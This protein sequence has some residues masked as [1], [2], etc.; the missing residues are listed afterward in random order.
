M[1]RRPKVIGDAPVEAVEATPVVRRRRRTSRVIDHAA[2]TALLIESLLKT[3]GSRGASQE[4]LQSVVNWA[5][6]VHA[7]T[8]E[9]KTLV[10]RPRRQK[11]LASPDRMAA[12]ELNKALLESALAGSIGLDVNENGLIVF[13][14][15]SAE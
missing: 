11:A 2:Q 8:E 1:G 3:R 9:L 12:Y 7:E 13:I 14:N 5:R 15:P 6:G 4:E 10:G